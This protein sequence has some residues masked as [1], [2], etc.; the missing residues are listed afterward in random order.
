MSD[1]MRTIE[2]RFTAWLARNA[3]ADRLS[4]LRLCYPIIEKYYLANKILNKP[5]FETSDLKTVKKVQQ[6]I[7]ESR[8]FQLVHHKQMKTIESAL[9]YY[10]AF[11]KET[12]A[13]GSEPSPSAAK[14][15]TLPTEEKR[16]VAD[17][18]APPKKEPLF[19]QTAT[20][21]LLH[22]R[23]PQMFERIYK[24]LR[25]A[26]GREKSAAVIYYELGMEFPFNSIYTVLTQASWSKQQKDHCFVFAGC[27][28]DAEATEKP[29]ASKTVS[30]PVASKTVP[31]HA[32][33]NVFHGLLAD[34]RYA[35][36]RD[37]LTAAGITSVEALKNINLWSFMNSHNL[38]SIQQ[39]LAISTELTA[40]LQSAKKRNAGATA[41]YEIHYNDAIYSGDTPS[42]AFAS[43]LTAIAAKYPLKFR[44]LISALHPKTSRVVV[45]RHD[46]TGG[47][48]KLMNPEAFIDSDLTLEEVELY[49]AWILER[50]AASP[51]EFRVAE[52]EQRSEQPE[53][54]W[55]EEKRPEP[56]PNPIFEEES[57]EED[58]QEAN[59]PEEQDEQDE[60]DHKAKTF[61][62]PAPPLTQKAEDYLLKR[63]LEG[64]SYD[65]LQNYL[66][67]TYTGT[68]DAVRLSPHIVE[69][70][71]RLYHDEAF[72]DF[73]EGANGIEEI[74][75]KLLKKNDGLAVA[76]QLWEYARSEITMFLNDNNITGQRA[77]YDLARHLFEKLG[78]HGKRY[79][80][81]SNTYISL[82]EISAKS[83]IG[84]LQKYT[85]EKGTTVTINEMEDY[86]KCLG[87]NN[88]NMRGVMRI[89]K[90]P[91]FLIY[92]ENE[93]LLADLIHTDNAFFGQVQ[94]AL[95][96]LFNDEG[97]HIILRRIPSSWYS[98]LPGLPASLEW[99]PM[100][101]QQ[102]L[103]YYSKRLG[104]RTIIAME[105][106]SSNTLHAMLVENNSHIQDFRDAVA[107]YLHEEMPERKS[108]EAEELRKLLVNAGML[109]GNEL[110]YNMPK[111]LGEDPR[112][113]WDSAGNKVSVRI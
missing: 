80:F 43:F 68:V 70:N 87:L 41:T 51:L 20:D 64:A 53:A 26:Q 90:E 55:E 47:K 103:Q 96:H 49:A 46:Y 109:S 58:T 10:T 66:N 5:L 84:I 102:L 12:I 50:C 27:V 76:A 108:F 36:L 73:E 13:E 111:A 85:R 72:V 113:L 63:D 40:K 31:V 81:H 65:E 92:R 101:L 62:S 29:V 75:D 91:I 78:Y 89:D 24:S 59:E 22:Q 57:D 67:Y 45:R 106:Q 110:I 3:P 100:L 39:R 4:E 6:T 44:G 19:I 86:L 30:V 99:T 95:K 54:A 38:Y 74:L 11:L 52:V 104:A 16:T 2:E 79:F 14:P 105:S 9:Q 8:L 21:K 37:A 28:S 33:K 35:D 7:M 107:V 48:L 112:F 83:N 97:D 98:L 93:Y 25:D 23:Q 15:V 17:T 34:D 18:K 71:D 42:E 56:E 77:V 69:M 32:N 1:N 88:G 94:T 61:P 60:Q 82:P